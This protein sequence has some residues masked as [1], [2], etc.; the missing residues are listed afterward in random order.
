MNT[1]ATAVCV[2][3][4]PRQVHKPRRWANG[5]VF[6][7]TCS[8]WRSLHTILDAYTY[9]SHQPFPTYIP[10]QQTR[11]Q[12]ILK[13]ISQNGVAAMKPSLCTPWPSKRS[14]GIGETTTPNLKPGLHA[15]LHSKEVRRSL[16]EHQRQIK[17][18]EVDGNVYVTILLTPCTAAFILLLSF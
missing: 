1:I 12:R 3:C 13:R 17:P 10:H 18:S 14:K 6:H 15:R 8:P 4:A 9:F 5:I 7:V 11:C 16:V 2:S